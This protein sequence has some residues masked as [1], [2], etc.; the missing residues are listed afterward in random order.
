MPACCFVLGCRTG[1]PLRKNEEKE[2][3]VR[4]QL[5]SAPKDPLHLEAIQKAVVR[6]RK[7]KKFGTKD[8]ICAA[9]FLPEDIIRTEDFNIN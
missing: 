1:L 7:D 3:N 2:N 6:N 9:H 8:Y 4:Y 5:F